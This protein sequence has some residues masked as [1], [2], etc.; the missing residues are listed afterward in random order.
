MPHEHPAE[1]LVGED[2]GEIVDAAVA[3]SLADH[4]DHLV[5]REPAGADALL[6]SRGVLHGL[7]LDLR[8]FNRH[9]SFSLR[10]DFRRSVQPL[11][12]ANAIC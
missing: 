3:F 2:G 11:A 12:V 7:Q 6:Q 9:P 5:C 8:D 1:R 10:N 4:R